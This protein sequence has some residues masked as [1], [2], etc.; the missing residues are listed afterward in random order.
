MLDAIRRGRGWGSPR[1]G[2]MSFI[3]N[4]MMFV[5]RLAFRSSRCERLDLCLL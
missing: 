3:V 2:S 5:R 4:A 1:E